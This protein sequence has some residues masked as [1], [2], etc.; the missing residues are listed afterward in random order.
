M[1]LD[2]RKRV[3][4]L[5][6][7]I[8]ATLSPTWAPRTILR[9]RLRVLCSY[10][11]QMRLQPEDVLTPTGHDAFVAIADTISWTRHAGEPHMKPYRP[12]AAEWQTVIQLAA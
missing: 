6:T 4:E 5:L 2:R 8:V 10:A 7:K 1:T 12:L 9:H 3:A 11:Q